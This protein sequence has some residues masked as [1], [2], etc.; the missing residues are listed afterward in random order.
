MKKVCQACLKETPIPNTE[1]DPSVSHG[2]CRGDCEQSY[3]LWFRLPDPAPT[4]D[5]FHAGR[6]K[7]KAA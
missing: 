6:M 4:L 3:K 2:I 1:N 7:E 5:T